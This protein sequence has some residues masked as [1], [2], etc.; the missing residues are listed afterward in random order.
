MCDLREGMGDHTFYG[1]RIG[2]TQRAVMKRRDRILR[3]LKKYFEN[4]SE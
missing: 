3:D 1:R 4:F 2:R